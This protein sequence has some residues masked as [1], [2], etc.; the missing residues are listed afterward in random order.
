[1]A[2]NPLKLTKHDQVLIN[3]LMSLVLPIIARPEDQL[4]QLAIIER[5]L[6]HVNR[7]HRYLEPLA[8]WSDVLIQSK[9]ERAS[10]WH[11]ATFQI[12]EALANLAAWRLG[13]LLDSL[14]AETQQ[15]KDAA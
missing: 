8:D 14:R 9:C 4:M 7:G 11:R 10:Q 1:M 6:P 5:V 13:L 15:E 2:D 3:A 12:N